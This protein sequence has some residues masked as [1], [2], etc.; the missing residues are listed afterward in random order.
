MDSN[1]QRLV[2]LFE[3]VFPDLPPAKIPL[4]TQE[5]VSAWDSVA[6]ITLLNLIEEEWGMEVDFA[7]VAE[8]TSFDKILE[9]LNQRAAKSA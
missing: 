9:Y 6:A 8:L 7:E 4:A 3:G 5:N 2:R 1:Q